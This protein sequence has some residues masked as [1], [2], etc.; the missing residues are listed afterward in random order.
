MNRIFLQ[1]VGVE[2]VKEQATEL[3]TEFGCEITT[4]LRKLGGTKFRIVF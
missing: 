1:F 3:K 4:F 2:Y